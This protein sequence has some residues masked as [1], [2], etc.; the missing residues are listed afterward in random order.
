[1]MTRKRSP[2]R[3]FLLGAAALL[4]LAGP[5]LASGC[6]GGFAPISKVDGL[7]V[8]SVV[9]ENQSAAPGTSDTYGQPGDTMTLR[10]T[11]ADTNNRP[12][13]VVWLAGCFDPQG[14]AYYNCYDSLGQLL[15]GGFDP[16]KLLASGLVGLGDTFNL[17]LPDDIISRRPKPAEGQPYYGIAYVFFAACAGT[18]K[19]VDPEGTS[20]AGSFPIRC[21]DEK[22][23]RLGADSFVPGYTQIYAF[24][25]GRKNE[26]PPAQG[27]TLGDQP[28]GVGAE[29]AATVEVCP[30]PE[31]ERLGPGGCSKQDAKKSCTV[32]DLS[33]DVPSDVAEID[34]SGKQADGSPLHEVVWVDYF[35][36]KGDLDGDA[37]LLTDA[38]EGY[39]ADHATT[40]I[41]P[42]KAGLFRVWAVVHDARGGQTVV[43]RWLNAK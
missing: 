24:A 38:V 1:M 39:Q 13:T 3:R 20:V 14:D 22:G 18:L 42:D 9:T 11:Y 8:L 43:E 7:R 30:V 12:I 10:M 23:N 28:L 37:K 6:A 31:D 41:P 36:E 15:Q 26:N 27:L 34:P 33:V 29:N 35:V 40:L 19:P 17:K 2:L 32:Y 5:P 16:A 21:F 25:D 4:T